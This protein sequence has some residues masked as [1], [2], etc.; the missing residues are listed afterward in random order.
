MYSGGSSERK[1]LLASQVGREVAQVLDAPPLVGALT[2][3]R[4]R[5]SPFSN[6]QALYL[7]CDLM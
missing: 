2:K 4:H 5:A 7:P 6:V 3:F 1:E